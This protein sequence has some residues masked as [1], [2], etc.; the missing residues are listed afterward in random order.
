[1][2]LLAPDVLAF[3]ATTRVAH[4]ATV[5]VDGSPL[6]LPICFAVESAATGSRL[7]LAL[8]EKPK[9]RAPDALE[10][11]RNIQAHP[12]VAVV[13][14]RWSEDWT[15]LAWVHLRGTARV[16]LPDVAA[17][18][19]LHAIAVTLLRTKYAQY[20]AMALTTRPAIAI[21]IEHVTTWGDLSPD[22]PGRPH[23]PEAT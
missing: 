8:D 23:G 9:R 16:L 21:A 5:S 11:V 13:A 7:F 6:V 18:T 19:T 14:D 17:D 10:R 15:R 22:T 3:L 12:R 20:A 1:M 2:I 4:L